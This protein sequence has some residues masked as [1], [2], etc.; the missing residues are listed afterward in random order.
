MI[1]APGWLLPG[2]F[3]L[4]WIVTPGTLL[5]WYRRMVKRKMGVPGC[6]G[7]IAHPG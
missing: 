3:C 6:R 5:A 7:A 1:A 2:H 4:H